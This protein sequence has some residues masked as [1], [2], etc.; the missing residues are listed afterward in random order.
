[1]LKGYKTLIIGAVVAVVGFL[2]GFDF[3]TIVKD[4]QTAGFITGGIG[5]LMMVLRGLTNT[6]V[7]S[8][9]PE[10]KD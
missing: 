7:A 9:K 2:Q 8:A 5:I 1:M 6:P 4:P 3:T 10:K